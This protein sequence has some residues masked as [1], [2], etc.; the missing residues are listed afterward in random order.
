MVKTFQKVNFLRKSQ[1]CVNIIGCDKAH[2]CTVCLTLGA[3]QCTE[4]KKV[5]PKNVTFAYTVIFRKFFQ[6]FSLKE[7]T[8]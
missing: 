5:E 4:F 3:V 1:N 8:V 2:L 7:T 6:H